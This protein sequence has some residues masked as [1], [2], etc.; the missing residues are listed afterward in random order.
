VVDIRADI[1]EQVAAIRAALHLD[2]TPA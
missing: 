2:T 1:A